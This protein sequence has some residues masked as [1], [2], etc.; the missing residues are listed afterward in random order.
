M[1]LQSVVANAWPR[2]DG[3][4]GEV[5]KG[6]AVCW[7]GC[8]E[9][10]EGRRGGGEGLEKVRE[11]LRVCVDMLRAVMVREGKGERF[12]SDVR[13]LV[14]ADGRVGGLFGVE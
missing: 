1:A 7:S 4:S 9:E 12:E 3:W 6:V 13:R 2:V 5:L 10:E 11:E 8:A 14:E